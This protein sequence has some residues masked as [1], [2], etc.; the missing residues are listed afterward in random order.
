MKTYRDLGGVG[1]WFGTSA[2]TVSKWRTR[3]ADS[4]PCPEPDVMIGT[5]PGW[6]DGR[7]DEWRRWEAGRPGRGA[8]GGRPPRQSSS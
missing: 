4:H 6:A 7:E 3:Y 8:G 2:A 5:T 1:E